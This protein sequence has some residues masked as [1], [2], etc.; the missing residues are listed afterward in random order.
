MNGSFILI[1]GFL[2]LRAGAHETAARELCLIWG[3]GIHLGF[4]RKPRADT[5]SKLAR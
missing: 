5:A 2:A 4:E 3:M 1:F